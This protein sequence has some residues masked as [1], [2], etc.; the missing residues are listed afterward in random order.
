MLFYKVLM[1]TSVPSHTLTQREADL[2][3]HSQQL[4]KVNLILSGRETHLVHSVQKNTHVC[5]A[6]ATDTELNVFHAS[7]LGSRLTSPV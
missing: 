1:S 3:T 7:L 6:L 2:V 4:S 5:P